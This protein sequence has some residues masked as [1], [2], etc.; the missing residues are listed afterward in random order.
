MVG[1]I[2]ND[3]FLNSKVMITS[4]NID[5]YG[6]IIK[7]FVGDFYDPWYASTSIHPEAARKDH[8]K[9][10]ISSITYKNLRLSVRGFFEYC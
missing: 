6:A 7:T 2:F 3:F 9:H 4:E 5:G 8:L 10:F 1:A